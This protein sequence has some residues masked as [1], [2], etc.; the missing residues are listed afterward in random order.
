MI[1]VISQKL[2]L[3]L[4]KKIKIKIKITLVII[5]LL[6]FTV[7]LSVR[8]HYLQIIAGQFQLLNLIKLN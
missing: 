5:S 6:K 8:E 1:N 7:N 2:K 4:A 3:L